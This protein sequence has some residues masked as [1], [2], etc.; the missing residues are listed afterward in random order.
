[1][2][3][4]ITIL[5]SIFGLSFQNS[6]NAQNPTQ[7]IK[8]TIIDKQAQYPLPGVSV[9]IIGSNPLKGTSTNSEGKFSLTEVAPGRYDLKVTF[10]E[11]NLKN[12]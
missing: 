1:M 8:G 11:G 9:I 3:K 2:K 4:Y 10:L 12:I 7:T 6:I 5:I